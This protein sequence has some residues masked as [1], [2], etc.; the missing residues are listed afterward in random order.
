[1]AEVFERGPSERA[2]KLLRDE[3]FLD[4]ETN[5]RFFRKRYAGHPGRAR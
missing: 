5:L 2:A 3:R 1:M 4:L